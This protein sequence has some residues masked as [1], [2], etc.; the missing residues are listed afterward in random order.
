MRKLYLPLILVVTLLLACDAKTFKIITPN[1][2]PALKVGD[3]RKG[4]KL[5]ETDLINR[6]DIVVFQLPEEVRK[7]TGDKPGAIIVSRII[8]LPGEKVEVKDGSVFVDDKLLSETFE[9]TRDTTRNTKAVLVPQ[10]EY[11]LL[12]DNRPESLDS[13]HWTKPTIARSDI[14]A[15]IE[16]IK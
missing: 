6:F 3:I 7:V 4:T 11:Y 1:M 13:R 2:A 14:S 15:R 8:G 5:N 12:G 10:N 9:V 16:E